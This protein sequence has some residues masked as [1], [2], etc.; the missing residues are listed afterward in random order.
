MARAQDCSLNNLNVN[1]PLFWFKFSFSGTVLCGP[2][3]LQFVLTLK[4]N[5]LLFSLHNT[6]GK[7]N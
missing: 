4:L 5:P 7:Q 1:P 3:T 6:S 2:L